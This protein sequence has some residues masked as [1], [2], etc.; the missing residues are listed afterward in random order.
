MTSGLYYLAISAFDNDPLSSGGNI[1]PSGI[2]GNGVVSGPTGAGGGSTLS[3][4]TNA[5]FGTGTYGITLTG[6]AFAQDSTSA[7]VPEP[8]S[9][10]LFG[11]GMLGTGAALRRRRSSQ[12]GS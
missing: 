12:Y 5:D 10:L 2:F 6:A 7:S 8:A 3:G 11:I 1:F 9:F 4:W